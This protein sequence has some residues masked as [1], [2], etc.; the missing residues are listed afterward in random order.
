MDDKSVSDLRLIKEEM[1]LAIACEWLKVGS[2]LKSGGRYQ[3]GDFAILE[4]MRGTVIPYETT[5]YTSGAYYKIKDEIQKKYKLLGL[6]KEAKAAC[7]QVN[8]KYINGLLNRYD[9]RIGDDPNLVEYKIDRDQSHQ[10]HSDAWAVYS[11]QEKTRPLSEKLA[12]IAGAVITL[13]ILFVIFSIVYG[14]NRTD[15]E[16]RLDEYCAQN[17]FSG[18]SDSA[19]KIKQISGK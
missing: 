5:S 7:K 3:N 9:I 17:G 19:E 4:K 11:P 10:S 13:F 14:D 8:R 18:C 1:R 2:V 15:E 16:K 12:V 6:D